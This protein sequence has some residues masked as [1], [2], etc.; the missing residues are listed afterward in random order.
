[1]MLARTHE[2]RSEL[3]QVFVLVVALWTAAMTSA[4]AQTVSS[5]P[6]VG[7]VRAFAINA[8]NPEA[9]AQL[10]RAGWLEAAG[11]LLS[12]EDFPLAFQ[13]IGRAWTRGNVPADRFAI[14]DLRR[15]SRT[16]GEIDA[17]TAELLGGDLVTGGKRLPPA[18]KLTYCIY[19]GVDASS[20]ALQGG[21]LVL[22][23]R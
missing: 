20:V 18:P 23:A 7:E 17:R 10:H 5:G 6:I 9:M 2:S 4:G 13:M 8:T 16:P 14:A 12:V 22:T 1:M 15:L 11:Q 19:V 21:R 3:T